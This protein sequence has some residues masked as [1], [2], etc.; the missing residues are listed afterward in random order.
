MHELGIVV[1]VIKQ[2]EELAKNNKVKEVKELTLEVGEVSGVV[3]EYFVDA[4]NWAIKKTEYMKN[5]KLNLIIIEGISFCE[6]CQQT[7]KTTEFGK[8]CPNCG[9]ERTY[10]VTGR[11]VVIKDVKV[12]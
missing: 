5:C 10:L 4:F 3:K 6:D 12:I 7:F 8:K 2:I 11:D 1:H 9:S